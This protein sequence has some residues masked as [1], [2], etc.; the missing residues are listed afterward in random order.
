LL[1]VLAAC[2]A[3]AACARADPVVGARDEDHAGARRQGH[4][5]PR[6]PPDRR[7]SIRVAGG[8]VQLRLNRRVPAGRYD[9]ALTRAGRRVARQA[10]TVS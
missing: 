5:L 8:K 6:G 4:A 10:V 3:A 9:L 1:G 2:V 7:G